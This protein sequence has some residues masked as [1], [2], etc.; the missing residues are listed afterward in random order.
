MGLAG[1]RDFVPVALPDRIVIE[2][3]RRRD[4]HAAGAKR[5][6]GVLVGDDRNASTGQRQFDEFAEE[7]SVAFVVRIDG[8]CAVT[9][10]GLGAGSRYHQMALAVGQRVAHVPHVA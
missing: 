9:E 6:I 3:V 5:G 8:Q 2:I 4:L 10:H 1:D 7:V